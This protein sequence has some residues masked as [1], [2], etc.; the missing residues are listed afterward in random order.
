[1][2]GQAA[3]A[4]GCRRAVV[5]ALSNDSPDVGRHAPERV[6]R[7][8]ERLRVPLHVW[9]L[10]K[11]KPFAAAGWPEVGDAST[12]PALLAAFKRLEKDLASQTIVWIEGDW[13][14]Q[15]IALAPGAEGI[16]LVK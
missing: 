3:Y 7:Y 4:C 15:E 6:A 2:A 14:P 11:P 16:E 8:L 9:S 5:L 13:M 10:E 12:V 1:M